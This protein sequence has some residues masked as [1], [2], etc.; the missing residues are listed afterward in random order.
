MIFLNGNC[1][2]TEF[3]FIFFRKRKF[4]FSYTKIVIFLKTDFFKKVIKKI[5]FY[6]KIEIFSFFSYTKD[7]FFFF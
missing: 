6:K 1:Y 5:I 2:L 7:L 4:L 3:F